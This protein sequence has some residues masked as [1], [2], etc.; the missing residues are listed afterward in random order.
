MQDST[1]IAQEV[2]R[3]ILENY[4]SDGGTLD[5]SDS[6]FERGILDSSGVLELVGFLQV[7]YAV[8]IDDED[9]TPENLGSV[10]SIAGLVKV[11]LDLGL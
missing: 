9:L 4:A 6:L 7:T 11:K 2:R 10:R 1:T 3:F 8:E 5:D